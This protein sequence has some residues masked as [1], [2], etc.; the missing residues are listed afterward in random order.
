MIE[1]I[2]KRLEAAKEQEENLAVKLGYGKAIVI[3][4]DVL[5]ETQQCTS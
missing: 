3:A 5:I 2:I 4:Y 1:E